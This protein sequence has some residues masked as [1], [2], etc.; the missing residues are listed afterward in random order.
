MDQET[1]NYIWHDPIKKA[2]LV[3]FFS[4]MILMSL[5][6]FLINLM[7]MGFTGTEDKDEMTSELRKRGGL[8]AW[9]YGVLHGSTQDGPV[10][11]IIAS[12]FNTFDPPAYTALQTLYKTTKGMVLG[13]ISGLE[14][15]ERNFGA[16]R[17]LFTY[18]DYA[19]SL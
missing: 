15:L 12:L 1:L 6:A 19:R 4:D 17:E 5:V 10:N 16:T 11:Q 8:L 14:W 2:N 13:N 3:L 9:S 7:F 18:I